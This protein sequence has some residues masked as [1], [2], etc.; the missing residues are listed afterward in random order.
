MNNDSAQDAVDNLL[1][2]YTERRV[3]RLRKRGLKF[4]H[5][6]TADVAASILL[7]QSIWMRNAAYMN[8][9]RE[10]A[11]GSEC[12]QASLRLYGA[13]FC[14]ALN[15]DGKSLGHDVITQMDGADFH[16]HHHTYLTCITE[17]RPTD[18]MGLL[19]M[20]RAYGGSTGVALI[21]NSDFLDIDSSPLAAWSSPVLYGD[22][23]Y[24]QEFASL[25]R[26]LEDNQDLLRSVD[27]EYLKRAV[28]NTLQFSILSTKHVGFREEREWRI[29]HQPRETTSP[30]VPPSFEPIRG[31]P[32]TVYHLPLA[33]TG[34]LDRPELDLARL[35]DRIIIGPSQYPYQLASTFSQILSS[36]RFEN[37]DRYIRVSLIPLR[38]T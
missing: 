34:D 14:Q 27:P 22:A 35:L 21:F 5:Y 9:F 23:A 2:D 38:Q 1:F 7:K 31:K 26:R 8:D 17:H 16:H 11:F 33:N 15:L 36:L 10:V 6:T 24:L 12:L 13:R 37:P 25:V 29:I 4:A 3:A 20:W 19:S 32:E 18:D 28:F 30:W